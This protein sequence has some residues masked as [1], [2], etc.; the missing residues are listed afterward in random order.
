MVQWRC[1]VTT[2]NMGFIFAAVSRLGKKS[3]LV[4]SWLWNALVGLICFCTYHWGKIGCSIKNRHFDNTFMVSYNKIRNIIFL[5]KP[6]RS[7]ITDSSTVAP[8]RPIWTFTGVTV[9]LFMSDCWVQDIWLGV[10]LTSWLRLVG[11]ISDLGAENESS[12][13]QTHAC[14]ILFSSYVSYVSLHNCWTMTSVLFDTRTPTLFSVNIS[15]YQWYWKYWSTANYH[16]TK[17]CFVHYAKFW[18]HNAVA[19]AHCTGTWKE[20]TKEQFWKM[21]CQNTQNYS[22]CCQFISRRAF[23]LSSVFTAA[24]HTLEAKNI[25]IK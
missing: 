19:L 13:F 7:R 2:N 18:L 11:I 9:Y 3:T 23:Q 16:K 6:Y 22:K 5:V 1:W 12:I 21:H 25:K 4:F 24:K 10:R 8:L 20:N 15:K 14:W 17:R